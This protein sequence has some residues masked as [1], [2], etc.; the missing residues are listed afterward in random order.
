MCIQLKLGP[1][2]P[3]C[4]QDTQTDYA[5][6][7]KPAKY[8]TSFYYGIITKQISIGLILSIIVSFIQHNAY[9]S[10]S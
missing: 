2:N 10:R 5:A 3:Y 4:I 9:T 8:I 1:H 6:S 7:T